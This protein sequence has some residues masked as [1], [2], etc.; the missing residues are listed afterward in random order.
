MGVCASLPKI[1]IAHRAG[2]ASDPHCAV[3]LPSKNQ[4]QS[5]KVYKVECCHDSGQACV[6][7]RK[8]GKVLKIMGKSHGKE[9]PKG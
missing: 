2:K 1:L 3:E 9:D 4:N 6:V 8:A 7:T 5:G